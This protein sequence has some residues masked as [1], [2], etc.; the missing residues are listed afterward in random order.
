ML[1]WHYLRA[2]VC[3]KGIN[4]ANL[5]AVTKI[6]IKPSTIYDWLFLLFCFLR[7]HLTECQFVSSALPNKA[8]TQ[9][10]DQSMNVHT[11]ENVEMKLDQLP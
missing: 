6:S 8:S 9:A 5:K 1:W 3:L 7:S 4:P 10:T 11:V 2:F